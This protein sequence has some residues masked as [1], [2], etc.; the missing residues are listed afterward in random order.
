MAITQNTFTGNGSN[1][2]PFSFTFKWL[3]PTDIKV[4]VG[5][6][7]KTA[8]THYNLQNLNYTTKT[9]GEV[10]FTGGNTP[11]SGAAIRVFR[12]TD[13]SAL[14]ATFNPGSAIR[15]QDLNDNFT[16]NLYVTQEISNNAVQIDGSQ[17]MLGDLNMG[18]Y[19]I[20]N[21]A[22]P[23]ASSNAAT[24]DYVDA[25]SGNGGIPGHT[26]W[27]KLATAGQ[28]TFSGT[29]D[30]G[31][32]L[33]YSPV[34]EQVYLNGALQQRNA[35][36]SADNGTSVVF[37]QALKL[38]DVVDIVCTNNL[39]SGTV[40]NAVNISYNSQFT[41][42]TTRTVAAKLADVFSVKDFGAVGD[43]VTDDTVSIQ[44]AIDA[45]YTQG[46]GVVFLPKGSYKVSASSLS[47]T[48][49]N[50]GVPVNS[51]SCALV[52]RKGVSLKGAGTEN[53]KIFSNDTALILLALVA[54]EDCTVEKLELYSN[55][56][57]VNGAGHGIFSLSTSGGA[58][59]SCR[60]NT[61]K[62]LYIHNVGSYG[63]ALQSGRPTNTYIENVLVENTGAD[64][65]DLKCRDT[66]ADAPTGNVAIGIRVKNQGLRVTGSAGID[67]RGIWQLSGISVTEFGGNASFDY[68]G[69]RFRTKPDASD[70]YT[71]AGAKSSLTNFYVC[72]KSGADKLTFTGVVSGSDYVSIT[73][74]FIENCTTGVSLNG[75]ANG[76]ASKNTIVNVKAVG[77]GIYGFEALTGTSSSQF[78]GCISESALTAGF[79][80]AGTDI[81]C[82]NC[83]S[84]SD[85]AATS[86]ASGS[87]AS[88]TQSNCKFGSDSG[89]HV[90][91]IT[92]GR[93]GLDA[94][95]T[96]TNIDIAI[97]PKGTGNLRF[98]THTANADAPIT[99]YITIKD[100]SGVTRKLAVIT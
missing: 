85:T 86:V 64:G 98:G 12:D 89:L 33:S 68:V 61:F 78:I 83:I 51:S 52:L 81:L 23:T 55:Y 29:G 80:I 54:P 30:Y 79:R 7:L 45:A 32:T 92:A 24:K 46:L 43:G 41:G 44:A 100:S 84:S 14:S 58:D 8:G 47:E 73:N 22:T 74:G 27:R 70:I 53:T 34:R 18:G 35:D 69:V 19:K 36:Y 1:L 4:S 94:K 97:N 39:V 77:S 72:S 62:D 71:L 67:V 21:L 25:L 42:Q 60:N 90:Y 88:F 38:N 6:V 65:V 59:N 2:G 15:A 75:N 91:Q 63:L 93:L 17:T 5:G 66:S 49:D 11:A 9:G 96:S 40:S 37:T 50:F 99:G 82:S 95:G 20:T 26:R 31:G 28:T 56:P 76:S 10:L 48:Y 57:T 87:V 16:Q 13:D 3:E